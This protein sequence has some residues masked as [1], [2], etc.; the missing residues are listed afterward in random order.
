MEDKTS[1]P[2]KYQLSNASALFK[3]HVKYVKVI[4][5]HCTESRSYLCK[6]VYRV[7]FA[8]MSMSFLKCIYCVIQICAVDTVSALTVGD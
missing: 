7:A 8:Y 5:I 4:L 3:H 6:Q 2:R 1:D